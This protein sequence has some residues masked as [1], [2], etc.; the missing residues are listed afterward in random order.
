MFFN[1]VWGNA[2]KP[3]GGASPSSFLDGFGGVL[4]TSWPPLGALGR[5]LGVSCAFFS[6]VTLSVIGDLSW[7]LPVTLSVTGGFALGSCLFGGFLG[8]F[9][10]GWGPIQH[11]KHFRTSSNILGHFRTFPNIL[12]CSEIFGD[13]RTFSESF[14]HV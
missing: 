8:G 4:G 13:V 14:E 3:R 5:I 9:L 6:S 2:G 7:G 11:F 12:G 10:G 1:I